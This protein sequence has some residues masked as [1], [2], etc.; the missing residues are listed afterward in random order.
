MLNSPQYLE[1]LVLH[2]PDIYLQ[3]LQDALRESRAVHVYESTIERALHRR[4]WRR[5]KVR[6]TPPISSFCFFFIQLVA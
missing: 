1:G 2:R 3:E 5:K 6:R 4:G